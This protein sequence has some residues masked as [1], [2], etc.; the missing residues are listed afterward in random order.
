MHYQEFRVNLA[1]GYRSYD[2]CSP[3]A[4][5]EED[6]HLPRFRYSLLSLLNVS[7]ALPPFAWACYL[8]GLAEFAESALA[9]TEVLILSAFAGFNTVV[10]GRL[11]QP[12]SSSR[13]RIRYRTRL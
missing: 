11:F 1:F 10:L 7:L 9:A 8:V 12:V 2:R 4:L 3:L 13:R 5:G 6:M